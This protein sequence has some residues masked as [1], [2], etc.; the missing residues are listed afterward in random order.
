[1]NEQDGAS[2]V[3]PLQ[4]LLPEA[5]RAVLGDLRRS[6]GGLDATL[7]RADLGGE[8]RARVR[9]SLDDLEGLLM[10]VVV[11]EFNA[12]KSTLINALL[13]APVMAEGVTPTTDR[14][15]LIVHGD[16]A[17]DEEASKE[18]VRRSHPA[19]RLQALALVDTPGTNA[20]LTEHQLLTERFV[21]RADL[22]L[23]VT[24]ADRPFTESERR[25]LEG[26]ASW[27]KEIVMVVNKADLLTP[28]QRPEVLEY[29]R[30]GA[31]ATLGE[32]PPVLLVSA[33]EGLRGASDAL[34][35][36]EG[37]LA[38]R[39]DRARIRLKLESA[40]GVGQRVLADA[41][42]ELARRMELLH[43]DRRTL[44]SVERQHQ[45]W[46]ADVGRERGAYLHRVQSTL[47]ELERRGEVFLDES[48]RLT[49]LPLLLRA[50]PFR[51][52]FEAEVLQGASEEIDAAIEALSDWFT[53]RSLQQWEDVIAYV[54]ER[55]RRDDE[56]IVGE[57]GGR[58]HYDRGAL[59]AALRQL[60]EGA[61]AK[62]RAAPQ[63]L[64]AALQMSVVQ[65]GLLEV[66]G[67]GIGAATVMLVTSTAWDVT[68]IA[69]GLGAMGLGLLVL[70]RR[71]AQAKRELRQ[72]L[73]ALRAELE[74]GLSRE[75]DQEAQVAVERLGQAIAPYTRF[76]RGEIE[77]FEEL[78]AQLAALAA[79]LRGLSQRT[80]A[81]PG[82]D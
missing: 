19:D 61:I 3:P 57:V 46:R 1:M 63:R 9:Q 82:G 39:G 14:V 4:G 26:I 6:L 43:E 54:N 31:R 15:T 49:Q 60:A 17:R 33:R 22:I 34:H 79:A 81:L 7:T 32:A 70:P 44:E 13:G 59:M 25:F 75:L 12:G 16:E 47:L 53:E 30:R 35:E 45:Q 68:G 66:G 18:F 72:R 64:A 38:A 24:S 71:R 40:I 69:A 41:Q 2:Q 36:L 11:G 50:E 78:E 37:L 21:P 65:A 10:L 67:L 74:R 55:R 73:S 5:A 80:R 76:V 51:R 8:A 52:R 48:V 56:R 58:F 77:R 23:F 42:A 28:E 27:G 62:E 20:I 29:V